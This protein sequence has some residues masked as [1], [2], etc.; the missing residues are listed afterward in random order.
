[1]SKNIGIFIILLLFTIN[2]YSLQDSNMNNIKTV[3]D[4][5]QL[6][7]KSIIESANQQL[8]ENDS[9]R[10]FD[11]NLFNNFHVYYDKDYVWA[12]LSQSIKYVPWN[13][14]F[15][16]EVTIFLYGQQGTSCSLLENP[17]NQNTSS[18]YS[19]YQYSDNDRDLLSEILNYIKIDPEKP[20]DNFVTIYEK[21]DYF[22]IEI[23]NKYGGE[24]FKIRK[25]DMTIYDEMSEELD[26]TEEEDSSELLE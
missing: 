20:M 6:G 12:S 13:S 1:M 18:P 17:E 3:E 25:N 10:N 16:F 15:A 8:K 4:Y 24:F 5:L 2:V 19:F 14:S 7:K 26:L 23:M 21:P 9:F 22:D 11:I